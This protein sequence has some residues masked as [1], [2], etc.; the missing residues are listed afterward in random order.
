MQTLKVEDKFEVPQLPSAGGEGG[1]EK[2]L[3]H[4]FLI[5]KIQ[6]AVKQVEI[7]REERPELVYFSVSA[8]SNVHLH[9]PHGLT[10]ATCPS[11]RSLDVQRPSRAD[12]LRPLRQVPP[13]CIEQLNDRFVCNWLTETM[14]GLDRDNENARVTD[15]L[16]KMDE[17]ITVHGEPPTGCLLQC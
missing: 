15:L 10:A 2:D 5:G 3:T 14:H 6:G 8:R 9:R 12:L 4:E 16:A 1:D 11:T 7:I 13:S 17:Y